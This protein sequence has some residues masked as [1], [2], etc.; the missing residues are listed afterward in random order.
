MKVNTQDKKFKFLSKF[1]N[2][3]FQ[4]LFLWNYMYFY[5][6]VSRSDP[7]FRSPSGVCN[8]D[9]SNDP[10]NLGLSGKGMQFL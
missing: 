2:F 3:Q 7:T 10:M 8:L 1:T 5:T 6:I 4:Q 9:D